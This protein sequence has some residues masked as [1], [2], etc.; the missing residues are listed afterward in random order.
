[1]NKLG[2]KPFVPDERDF[3]F[4][5]LKEGIDLPTPPK[6]FGHG[7]A[8]KD[9]LMLGNGPDDSVEPGFEGCGDCVLADA[10]HITM[11]TNKMAGHPVKITGKE[12]VADYSAITGYVIG[13]D[14]TDMGT[15]MRE[16][17]QYRRKTGIMDANG[18]RHKIGAFV[19]ID[20]KD[21]DELVQ[22]VYVFT[23]V[24]IGFEFPDFAWDQFD[25]HEVWDVIDGDSQMV[26]GH[27]VPVVGRAYEG[28]IGVVTWAERHGMTPAFY[29]ACNDETWAVIYPEELRNGKTERGFDL[30][31]L[32]AM[33]ASL[34]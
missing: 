27:D 9:W 28:N 22:A 8:Y 15:E 33:L 32:N 20:P 25:N 11:L 23:A 2:K 12:V 26:G 5:A 21:V 18:K 10:G 24:C 34:N 14:S 4:S 16:A 6:Q 17:L 31:Q 19:S 13:D 7:L 29:E 30:T 3:K 1:M